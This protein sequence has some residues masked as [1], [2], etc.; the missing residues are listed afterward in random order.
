M[1]VEPA[2][3]VEAGQHSVEHVVTLFEGPFQK[4]VKSGKSQEEAMTAFSDEYFT[5]LAHLMVSKG[6]WFD[7]TLIAYWNRSFQWDIRARKDPR[8]QYITASAK[9]FW[10]AFPDLP[11]DRKELL[12][13]AYEKFNQITKIMHREGV[14]FL[15]G[16]D[17][18]AKYS[19][20]GFNVHDEL[21]L[22]VKAG[23]TPNEALVAATRNCAESLGILDRTG[24]IEPTKSADLVLLDA[25]PLSD[26]RNTTKI[27]AVIRAGKIL[28]RQELDEM[29]GEVAANAPMR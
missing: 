27:F 19:L 14:R 26:I 20:P 8:D 13:K 17:L 21:N 10:K 24:T 11:D 29:L 18:G 4:L 22:L 2:K 28:K 25:D 23:L 5:K 6:T 1:D 7:P 16:T 3:A 12:A 15:V 9:E